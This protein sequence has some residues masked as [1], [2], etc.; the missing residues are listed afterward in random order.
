MIALTEMP[1]FTSTTLDHTTDRRTVATPRSAHRAANAFYVRF[2]AFL[3]VLLVAG[4][5]PTFFFRPFLGLEPL[6]MPPM[7]H[8]V[9]LTTWFVLF[10]VQSGLVRNGNVALH[11]KLGKIGA[12]L[13]ALATLQFVWVA[14]ALYQGRAPNVDA[15]L[16]EKA[17]IVRIVSELMV[18]AAFPIFVA[19][20][21][22]ARRRAAVHKRLMLIATIALMPPV[23]SRLALWP[24]QVWPALAVESRFLTA[25][26]GTGVL[27]VIVILHEVVAY[28]RVH[29]ALAVGAPVYFLWLV[30]SALLLPMLMF[31]LL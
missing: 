3:L 23:L 5:G 11:R 31:R 13:A 21:V 18:F 14:V 6:A 28:R 30:G 2:A 4:F 1:M 24:G 10:F 17:R 15:D 27:L 8:G 9:V 29:F 22:L 25:I 16:V 7:L 12:S 20:A 26:A 19:L